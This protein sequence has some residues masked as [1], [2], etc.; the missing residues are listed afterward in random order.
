MGPSTILGP[1][2]EA[3]RPYT[4]I[5][6]VDVYMFDPFVTNY[7]FVRFVVTYTNG[8]SARWDVSMNNERCILDVRN[9]NYDT[10]N[11]PFLTL[12][13]M[14][15]NDGESDTD[16]LITR[17]MKRPILSW[18][19]VLAEH[20]FFTRDV[21]SYHQTTNPDLTI[22]VLDGP[23]IYLT[24]QAEYMTTGI[25][26]QVDDSSTASGGKCVLLQEPGEVTY[27]FD[28]S[29]TRSNSYI[30]MQ[31]SDGRGGNIVT[32]YLDGVRS[33]QFVTS[34]TGDWGTYE[35]SDRIPL[36]TVTAGHH[37][38][39]ITSNLNPDGYM[40]GM[41]LALFQLLTMPLLAPTE[42]V[43]ATVQATA[44]SFGS[45]YQFNSSTG[46]IGGLDV[47]FPTNGQATYYL[48]MTQSVAECYMRLRYATTIGPNTMHVYVDGSEKAK[49]P[50][51]ATGGKDSFENPWPLY[52][53][54]LTKGNHELMITME[55]LTNSGVWFDQFT[56]HYINN[57]PELQ[58]GESG[59]VTVGQPKKIQWQ[60]VNLT[61]HL[62]TTPVVIMQPLSCSDTNPA[63]IRVKNVQRDRFQFQIEEWAYE[64]GIHGTET[65]SYVVMEKGQ[66]RLSDGRKIEVGLDPLVGTGWKALTLNQSFTGTPVVLAQSQA[67]QA[68]LE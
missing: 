36:G 3:F 51:R 45:G 2:E 59:T 52:L 30:Q 50:T 43:F 55:A 9:A 35:Y 28:T 25:A 11:L 4:Q 41:K 39:R 46:A 44:L 38:L 42:T 66:H 68:N 58:I 40:D 34:T 15:V 27:D 48:N 13:S 29:L 10:V 21:P 65:V 31:Y 1:A 19:D 12:R 8:T 54:T 49:F 18:R 26:F 61:N 23:S 63:H 24:R 37:K 64:D 47:Y 14:W 57:D 6:N 56:L 53:G 33:G 67:A 17:D 62:Y 60:T 22:Q 32:V 20:W 5:S 16:R 7:S